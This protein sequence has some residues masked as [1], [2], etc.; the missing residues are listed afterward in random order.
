MI[1]IL[2]IGMALLCGGTVVYSILYIIK[3]FNNNELILI[4]AAISF[5]IMCIGGMIFGIGFLIATKKSD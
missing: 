1:N 2:D 3:L 4:L 5:L